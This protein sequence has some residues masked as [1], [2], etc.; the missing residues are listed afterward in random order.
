M[1]KFFVSNNQIKQNVIEIIGND[2]NHISNVLRLS[3]NDEIVICNKD[4]GENYITRI[5]EIKKDKIICEVLEKNIEDTNK[6]EITIFQGLPKADKMELIIQKCT[7]LGVTEITPVQMER[8]VVKLD[9]KSES[10]KIER[11]QKIAEAASKQCRR[12]SI[13]K[14]NSVTN[15]KNICNVVEDYDILLVPYEEEQKTSFKEILHSY[16][17]AKNLKI[18][19]V[20]G[21]EGGFDK[22]EIDSLKETGAKII[23]L[24]KRILRTETVAIAMTSAI[25][26]EFNELG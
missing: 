17:N 12:N 5:I 6:V 19:I 18:A 3:I 11:W 20:I 9:L 22:K 24:G 2:V 13:C 15:I 21:P 4:I 26:Y 10:K 1:P 16:V 23:T 25:M 14:I 8:C 7:E